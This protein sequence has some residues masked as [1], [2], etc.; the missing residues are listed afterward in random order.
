ME[1]ADGYKDKLKDSMTPNEIA[2]VVEIASRYGIRK[3]KITGGEPLLRG[4]ILDIVGKI[5]SITGIDEVSMVTN[6]VLLTKEIT[7]KLKEF[8]GLDRVNISLPSIREKSYKFISGTSKPGETLRKVIRGIKYAVD[9]GLN[10]VKINMVLLKGVNDSEVDEAI[11]FARENNAILQLIELQSINVDDDFYRDYH[12]DMRGIEEELKSKSVKI[13]LR[14]IH[15]RK[16]YFLDDGSIVEVVKPM[17]NTDFCMNCKRLRVTFSGEFK[18]CLMRTDN[19]VHFLSALREG[20]MK[21]VEKLFL[22]AIRERK[23]FFQCP[24]GCIH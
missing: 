11:N 5:K 20:N 2:K 6:G 12:Y 8:A 24:A 3:V 7:F 1:D 10:P 17:H 13:V 14:D 22:K 16:Q 19:H 4:D 18:P 9:V 15:H 21:R 23:P